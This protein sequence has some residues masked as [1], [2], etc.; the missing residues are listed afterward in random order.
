MLDTLIKNATILDGTGRKAYP[1]CVGILN[2]RLV[3]D[4]VGALTP[5]I[6]TIDAKGRYLAPGFID[7]HSHGDLIF[8]REFSM[9]AKLC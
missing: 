1:G 6:R 3:L 7:A 2:G 8:D 4:G 9:R 5:A